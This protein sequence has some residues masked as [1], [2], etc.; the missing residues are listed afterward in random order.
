MASEQGKQEA[1]LTQLVEKL[2]QCPFKTV[3]LE[4]GSCKTK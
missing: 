4:L 3:T 2:I 1:L